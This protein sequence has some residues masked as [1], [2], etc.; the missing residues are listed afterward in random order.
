MFG[1]LKKAVA[2]TIGS[3]DAALIARIERYRGAGSGCDGLHTLSQPTIDDLDYQLMGADNSCA[4]ANFPD[5]PE[6]QDGIRQLL[7]F[8]LKKGSDISKRHHWNSH[9]TSYDGG[10]TYITETALLDIPKLQYQASPQEVVWHHRRVE[11]LRA[12]GVERPDRIR[13]MTEE[14]RSRPWV[15]LAAA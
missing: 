15:S 7:W 11:E 12:D 8:A 4:H 5:L 6:G 10:K 2:A 13:I 9:G 14:R 3:S 1:F